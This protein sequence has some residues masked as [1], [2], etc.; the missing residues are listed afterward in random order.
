MRSPALAPRASWR[1]KLSGMPSIVVLL[2]ATIME[3]SGDA[4]VRLALFNHAGL[5]RVGFFVAGGL[6]LLGYGTFLNLAP[7]EFRQVIG[8]YLAVLFVVWQAINFLVFRTAP[9]LPI[10]VGGVLIVAGGLIITFWKTG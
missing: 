2:I 5:V 7:L 1:V 8:L 9:T 6:L 4:V 3:V 10:L